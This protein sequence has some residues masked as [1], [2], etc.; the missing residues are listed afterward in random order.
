MTSSAPGALSG[1]RVVDLTRHIPGP[2]CTMLLGDLGAD[3]IKIEEPP[4]GDP[5]RGVPP[6]AGGESAVLGALNRNKRSL[7]VDLRNEE[8][9]ALVRRLAA[10]ADVF[11]E[12]SRPGVLA[13]RGLGPVEL[14]EANPRLVYCSLSGYGQG[15]PLASRAG[16]DIDYL[17]LGGFLGT[18]RSADGPVLPATQVADMTGGL[19][20]TVAVL[21]ALQARERTGRAARGRVPPRGRPLPDDHPGD[22]H[23]GR[24]RAGGRAGRDPCLLPRVP[25][26]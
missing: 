6:A 25:M 15:G 13:R 18:N 26:P 4:M 24:R 5:T 11:V 22:A 20:A 21:A 1:L 3:V 10:R 7:A 2:Y 9:A 19:V 23:H 16:H 8:D 17:A 12:S 14:R